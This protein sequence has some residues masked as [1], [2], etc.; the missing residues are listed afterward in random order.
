VVTCGPGDVLFVAAH[1]EHRFVDFSDDFK[2]WVVFYGP[3]R[4]K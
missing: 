4:S 3:V 1:E 2:V